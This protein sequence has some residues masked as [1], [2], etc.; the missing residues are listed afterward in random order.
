MVTWQSDDG[1]DGS[2]SCIRGRLYNADGAAAGNDFV[3]NTTTAS[4]QV[5]PTV[6]GTGR[7]PLR[8]DVA[9]RRRRR[10]L[11]AAASARRLYNVDGTAAGDDF[12]VNTTTTSNQIA[13]SVTAL[14]DG[15]F[16][17][18]WESDDTGDG[19]GDCIRAQVF[20]PTVFNGTA[21]SRHLAGRQPCRRR[22]H[23]GDGDDTLSGG[24]GD[25]L[26]DGG[27]GN[28]TLSGDAARDGLY[29][30]D[31]STRRAA[32]RRVRRDGQRQQGPARRRRP[33]DARDVER[34][35]GS[36]CRHAHRP[37]GNDM[38]DGGAGDDTAVFSQ[39]STST[40]CRISAPRSWSPGR[41]A[42]TR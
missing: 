31:G 11:R 15:R 26:I 7:R 23:G 29:G 10:R 21:G 8:G 2:G 14:A 41:T 42:P 39:T 33:G 34:L 28:D 17:V 40:R 30:G 25:D 3:V 27:A 12:V 24:R 19:S 20:D 1:G 32:R 37:R 38:L 9:V 5:H 13:P 35:L 4:S 16:V 22:S 36:A 6:D 18:T